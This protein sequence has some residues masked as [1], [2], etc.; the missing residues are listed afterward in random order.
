MTP[1]KTSAIS[2]CRCPS[3]PAAIEQGPKLVAATK[4][5]DPWEK[6]AAA[7]Q[8]K[9]DQRAIDR[10]VER[11]PKLAGPVGDLFT[12]G[13]NKDW[14]RAIEI[15][16]KGITEKTTDADLLSRRA[17]AHEALKNWD[18]AAADWSRAASWKSGRGQDCSREFARRLAAAGQFPLAKA[19]FE[20]SEALYTRS[21][22]AD[23]E[24]DVVAADL[25]QCSW[26]E[27]GK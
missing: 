2:A 8:L 16:S 9:G 3:D 4:L 27:A 20:K 18:A 14:Q 24:N 13:A 21:L 17:R 10:L 1:P 22:A 25:A 19:Q 6:L 5:T 11:R 26:I 7:Y 23:P 15:Y 12:T